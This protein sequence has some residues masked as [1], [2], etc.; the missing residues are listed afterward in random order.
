MTKAQILKR[1]KAVAA[2]IGSVRAEGLNPSAKT[3]KGLKEYA[4]GKMTISQL[5]QI[6]IAD[7]KSK[8]R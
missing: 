2:A 5:R 8:S 6:T 3:Q 1:Q 7:V 4:K